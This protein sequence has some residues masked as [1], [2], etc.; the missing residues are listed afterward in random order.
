MI[1]A[2]KNASKIEAFIG[3]ETEVEGSIR[4]N[5]SIRIDGK[6]KGGINAESVFIGE[7]GN[8]L[9]DI[10]ANKVI[11]SGRVKGNISSASILEL[12]P[13]GIVVGDIRTSKLIISDGAS[14][15][16]NCQMLKSDGQIIEL[17]PENSSLDGDNANHKHLKVVANSKH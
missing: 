4:T 17:T 5:E 15:E 10:T 16:G 12:T 7:H 2:K 13:K 3:Q 6:I 8:I 1:F 14:F 11:V 9:G